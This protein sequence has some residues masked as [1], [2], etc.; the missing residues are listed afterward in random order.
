VFA[1]RH[2][3]AFTTMLAALGGQDLAPRLGEQ[4]PVAELVAVL[5]AVAARAPCSI[6]LILVKCHPASSAS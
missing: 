2:L 5:R 3:P 4:D 6:L 1:V